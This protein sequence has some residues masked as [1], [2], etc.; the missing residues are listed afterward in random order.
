MRLDVDHDLLEG[1]RK[2]GPLIADHAEEAERQRRPSP[3]VMA[4]VREAGLLRLFT[5]RSLG[6]LEVD[7]VTCARVI[8]EVAGFDSAAGWS[9]MVGNSVD[10]W[11]ARLPDEGP[12]ELYA[13]GPDAVIAAAFHPPIEAVRV[14]GGYRVT[15]RNPLAS[16]IHEASWL[17]FTA[18]VAGDD[19]TTVIGAIVAAGEA[20]VYDTWHSLGMRGTD[21]N[22]VAVNDVFVPAS[23]TFVLQPEFQPG[24]RYGGALYRFP[25]MGEAAVVLCPVALAIARRAL[26]ELHELAQGKTPFGAASVLR[27]RAVAQRTFA[28]AEATL[29]SARLLFYDTLRTTWDRTVAGG[30]FTLEQKAD[31]ALAAAHAT[32]SAVAAVDLVWSLAGSTGLYARNRLE[33]HFRDIHT[34]QHHGFVSESRYETAG[35]V[36]LGVEPEFGLVA[37]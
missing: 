29:R 19:P 12:E 21:S 5:P 14:E 16:N 33:R 22:D 20:Q 6:G 24:S 1:A 13:A 10:W 3:H 7:P 28:R 34:I 25:G 15:G 23:R 26:D 30:G 2:L 18:L 37:F 8:E 35:Q 17:M 4:A 11:C 32:V 27:E 36:Y 31:L 9:L